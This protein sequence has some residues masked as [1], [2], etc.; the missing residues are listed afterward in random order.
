MSLK[1]L[2]LGNNSLLL[3]LS[4]IHPSA[5]LCK[6]SFYLWSK[7]QELIPQQT[8]N[9]LTGNTYGCSW[10]CWSLTE[11]NWKMILMS[12]LGLDS[13]GVFSKRP[14]RSNTR[15]ARG[16]GVV[17]GVFRKMKSPLA[18]PPRSWLTPA[19]LWIAPTQKPYEFVP[20]SHFISGCRQS[21]PTKRQSLSS[22]AQPGFSFSQH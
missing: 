16:F 18:L 10:T 12:V 1:S 6:S 22:C 21:F 11:F 7:N 13:V 15:L 3:L 17:C 2:K 9:I 8:T 4:P 19:S 5:V 14:N 20:P